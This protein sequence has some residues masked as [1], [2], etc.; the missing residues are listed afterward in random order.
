LHSSAVRPRRVVYGHAWQKPG[1]HRIT[2][3]VSGTAG[4]PRV[5]VDGFIVVDGP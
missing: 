1:R 3:R 5:D 2:I 4:H